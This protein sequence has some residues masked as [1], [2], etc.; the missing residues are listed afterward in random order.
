MFFVAA[1]SCWKVYSSS[2]KFTTAYKTKTDKVATLENIDNNID[3]TLLKSHNF[4]KLHNFKGTSHYPLWLFYLIL[5]HSGP[6]LQ[7][8]W[9][10]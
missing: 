9:Y 8:K 1:L 4:S 6:F 10:I 3:N 5:I 7:Q 2:E